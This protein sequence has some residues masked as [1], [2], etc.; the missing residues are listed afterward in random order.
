[1]ENKD[2][3]GELWFATDYGNVN[4]NAIILN[5][6]QNIQD[7]IINAYLKMLE[8]EKEKLDNVY[9]VRKLFKGTLMIGDAP[10]QATL[11]LNVYL[12]FGS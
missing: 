5:S 9:C 3:D 12:N 4:D 6:S 11:L 2:Y 1:M 8:E 10:F 7:N